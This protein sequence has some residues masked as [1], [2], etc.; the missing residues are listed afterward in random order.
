MCWVTSLMQAAVQCRVRSDEP[1]QRRLSAQV[2]DVGTALAAA[3]EHESRLDEDLAAVVQERGSLRDRQREASP[4]PNRSAKEPRACR[5]TCDTTP[6][7]PASTFTRAVLVPFT[8]KVPFS[9]GILLLRH[10]QFP[11][12]EG[13]FCGCALIK[14]RDRVNDRG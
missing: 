3:R 12:S 1:E 5:P 9:R 4:R 13:P 10:S 7:P 2:L 6:V 8:L 14:S 11:L